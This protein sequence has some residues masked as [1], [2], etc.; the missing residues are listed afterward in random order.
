VTAPSQPLAEVR[1]DFVNGIDAS[2]GLRYR[3]RTIDVQSSTLH[4]TPGY[5]DETGVGAPQG[6]SFFLRLAE[7]HA[8]R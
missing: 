1:T 8:H 6:P 7:A 3:L 2:N 5:D 4:S